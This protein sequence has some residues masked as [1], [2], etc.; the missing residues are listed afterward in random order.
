[1]P[2]STVSRFGRGVVALVLVMFSAWAVLL[3]MK[4]PRGVDTGVGVV[5]VVIGM[6]NILMYRTNTQRM[7]ASLE[8]FQYAFVRQ[9]WD[10]LGEDGLRLLYLGI[11]VVL[12]TTGCALLVKKFVGS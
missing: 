9:F 12:L 2:L 6:F 3:L 8:R 7:F 4:V 10:R 1:M 5:L 11:G